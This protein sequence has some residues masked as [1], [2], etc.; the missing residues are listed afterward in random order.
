MPRV[1]RGNKRKE[2]RKKILKRA[3][4]YFLTNPSCIRLRKR[5][6]SAG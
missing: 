1:K 6:S 2:Y 4:G 3:S 5:Q